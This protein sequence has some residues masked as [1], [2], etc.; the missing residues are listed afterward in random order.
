MRVDT[1]ARKLARLRKVAQ[2]IDTNLHRPLSLDELAE[3]AHLSRYHFERV[4]HA[5]A[6]ET[7]LLR[8]RRL[9][10]TYARQRLEKGM[11]SSVTELALDAGYASAEA[12]SRAFRAQFGLAPSAVKPQ[13]SIPEPIRVKNLPPTPIQF[14]T[15]QGRFDESI[16][17]FKK[18]RAHALLAGIARERRKG[19]CIHLDGL[20][21]KQHIQAALLAEPLGTRI[22]GL[23]QGHLPA[24]EYA[25]L[26]IEGN[27][28]GPLPEDL[29]E[30][31]QE[32]TGRHMGEGHVLRRFLNTEYLPAAFEKRF[33][34]YV[35]LAPA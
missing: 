32:S 22:L 14:L 8:V 5:Y 28:S 15:F 30:R 29:E 7:P 25:V 33:D 20:A 27:H 10:L 17:P 1:Y 4:F 34:L 19:W 24:G 6:G 16:E 23:G 35:P 3:I 13:T 12:F 31:I 11:A 9:R 26:R 18:L 2:Y 21:D